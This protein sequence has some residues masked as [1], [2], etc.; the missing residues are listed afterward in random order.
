MIIIGLTG[1]IGHGKS[2]FGQYLANNATTHGQWESGELIAEVATALRASKLPSPQPDSLNAINGWLEPLPAILDKT[3]HVQVTRPIILTRSD[4]AG[5]SPYFIKLLDYLRLAQADPIHQH[6]PITSENKETVRP[7]LQWLGGY[8]AKT[9][10]DDIWYQEIIR[11]VNATP[12]LQIAL[13]GGVRFPADAACLR[14]AGGKI[15][16]ITRPR[17]DQ[18]D[19]QDLTERERGLI[20]FDSTIYN[21]ASLEQL[22]TCAQQVYH[23]LTTGRLVVDYRASRAIF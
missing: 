3:V 21:D 19:L 16:N 17:L 5:D 20:R 2:T 6:N 23:D 18:P 11:R 14:A 13:I 10:R 15:I 1:G 8:L 9:I 12:N 7:L 4:L 22:Q